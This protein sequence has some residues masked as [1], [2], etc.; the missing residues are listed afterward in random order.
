MYVYLGGCRN[1]ISAHV[2]SIGEVCRDMRECLQT[3]SADRNTRTKIVQ[4][5]TTTSAAMSTR[6]SAL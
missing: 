1:D 3:T 6:T 5:A 2:V 4:S